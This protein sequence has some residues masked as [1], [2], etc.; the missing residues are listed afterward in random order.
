[1]HQLLPQRRHCWPVVEARFAPSSKMCTQNTC[2]NY[3]G[4]RH[5][6]HRTSRSRKHG[7]H[8]HHALEYTLLVQL[9]RRISLRQQG[10]TIASRAYSKL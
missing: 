3:N 4:R 10:R 2:T 9:R 8:L 7:Q 5:G 1:M 6:A